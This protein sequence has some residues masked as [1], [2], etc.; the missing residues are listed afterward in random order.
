[1]NFWDI[2]D[3]GTFQPPAGQGWS[4]IECKIHIEY[5]SNGNNITGSPFTAGFS[6]PTGKWGDASNPNQDFYS[7]TVAA[8]TSYFVYTVCKFKNSITLATTL[9]STTGEVV[10]TGP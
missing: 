4:C 5:L 7:P 10:T 3:H 6:N 2:A 1:M 9:A 8:N